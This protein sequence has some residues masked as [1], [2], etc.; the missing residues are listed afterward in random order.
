MSLFIIMIMFDCCCLVY[1]EMDVQET[2]VFHTL[3]DYHTNQCWWLFE[4]EGFSQF[5][6]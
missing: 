2:E 3:F 4:I 5:A 6:G 1:S